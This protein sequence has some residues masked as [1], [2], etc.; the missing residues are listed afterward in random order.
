MLNTTQATLALNLGIASSLAS[1]HSI[2]LGTDNTER[3][4][5]YLATIVANQ[6][7]WDATHRDDFIA[8]TLEH[9]TSSR[10]AYIARQAARKAARTGAAS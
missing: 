10:D 7:A 3:D 1:R 8:A 6:T 2:E 5:E 9:A 4:A